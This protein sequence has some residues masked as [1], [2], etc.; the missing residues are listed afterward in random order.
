MLAVQEA[1]E[2]GR[3]GGVLARSLGSAWARL[4]T[5]RLEK[6]LVVPT[7]VKSVAIGGVTLG[8]SGK[9]PFA[10]AYAKRAAEGGKKVALVGHAHRARPGH[11]RVVAADDDVFVVGDEA[12]VCARELA[13]K[14][15]VV[16]APR[17][18]DAIDLAV[19]RGA[20]VIVLDGVHQ[21]A[22]RRAD[23]AILVVDPAA[24]PTFA[25]PPAGDLR[26]PLAAMRALAD[27]VVDIDAE[28]EGAFAPDGSLVSWE[29]LRT[30]K[31]GL[32]LAVA[33]QERIVRRLARVGVVPV[34]TVGELDHRGHDLPRRLERICRSR[35][36][37]DAWLMT[38]KC[39]AFMRP[40]DRLSRRSVAPIH[41][42]HHA[43]R[44]PRALP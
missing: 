37:I 13:G 36:D 39:A 10:I 26:A 35:S 4:A 7:N 29:L 9:T 40:E 14:V 42:I 11:A 33:H 21:I 20:D 28:S 3:L 32:A 25:C 38:S 6:R 8:G 23:V 2:N 5:P 27:F 24:S 34:L 18:Q 43:V 44:I 1:L 30:R 17:R 22:P 31:M 41:V 15:D 16:V 19:A 12:L